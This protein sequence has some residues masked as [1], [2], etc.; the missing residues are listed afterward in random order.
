MKGV[1]SDLG[2]NGFVGRENPKLI[3]R[4]YSIALSLINPI[5]DSSSVL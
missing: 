1:V 3:E 5:M 4:R 2:L